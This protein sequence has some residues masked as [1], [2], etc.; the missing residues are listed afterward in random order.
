M[1]ELLDGLAR[2]IIETRRLDLPERVLIDLEDVEARL[3]ARETL[4]DAYLK[5][6]FFDVIATRHLDDTDDTHFQYLD[7]LGELAGHLIGRDCP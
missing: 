1:S 3:R 4:D 5:S 6:I 2:A 7:L